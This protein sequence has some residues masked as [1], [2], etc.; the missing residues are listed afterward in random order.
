MD[1]Y[2][3]TSSH[4]QLLC[5]HTEY[6]Q[7]LGNATRTMFLASPGATTRAFAVHLLRP[8]VPTLRRATWRALRGRSFLLE[9]F[10]AHVLRT[11]GVVTLWVMG[12]LMVSESVCGGSVTAELRNGHWKGW[13]T[14][15]RNLEKLC[16]CSISSLLV[17][18]V[19]P[20]SCSVF[21]S[22]FEYYLAPTALLI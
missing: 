6:N 8:F 2:I 14:S 4:L 18:F 1:M 21:S 15:R 22:E 13:R 17:P 11:A 9:A 16:C 7:V 5:I 3:Y 10:P 20:C 12:I 19:S